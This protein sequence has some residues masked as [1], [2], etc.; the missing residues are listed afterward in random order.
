MTET[1]NAKEQTPIIFLND[2]LVVINTRTSSINHHIK[3]NE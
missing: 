1:A 2:I 3:Y